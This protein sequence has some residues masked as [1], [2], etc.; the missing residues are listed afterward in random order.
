LLIATTVL[1]L[2]V[3]VVSVMTGWTIIFQNLYYLPII[4]ACVFY[5]RREHH[6]DADLSVRDKRRTRNLQSYLKNL[7]ERKKS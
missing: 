5:L 6:A 4:I 2:G 1:A 3:S 7:P